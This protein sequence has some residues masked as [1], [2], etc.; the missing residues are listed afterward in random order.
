MMEK[1]EY[2]I[3]K[4]SANLL[5]ENVDFVDTEAHGKRWTRTQMLDYIIEEYRM[6]KNK[7][8]INIQ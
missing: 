4:I 2:K 3:K 5:E 7:L 8:K 1:Y 6:M